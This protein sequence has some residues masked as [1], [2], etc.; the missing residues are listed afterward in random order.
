MLMTMINED[1]NDDDNDDDYD[2]ND[3]DDDDNDNNDDDI[4]A[5]AVSAG[6]HHFRCP[7][8]Q[9]GEYAATNSEEKG[10]E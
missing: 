8:C 5:L 1:D 7:N 4:Q 10:V 9:A 2:D 6:R 3:D